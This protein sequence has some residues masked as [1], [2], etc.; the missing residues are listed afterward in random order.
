M[1][2]LMFKIN[3]SLLFNNDYLYDYH[4]DMFLLMFKTI[5]LYYSILI[6]YILYD[7]YRGMFLLML[8]INKSLLFNIDYQ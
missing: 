5:Y 1:Y 3:I 6:I 8:K 4:I 2:L 7:Y